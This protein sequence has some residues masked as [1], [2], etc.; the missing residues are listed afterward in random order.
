MDN[1][2]PDVHVNNVINTNNGFKRLKLFLKFIGKWVSAN[3]LAT[4]WAGYI[5]CICY[6]I[7]V[8]TT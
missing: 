4:K 6:L 5:I 2:G 3:N 8:G 1:Y 7:V